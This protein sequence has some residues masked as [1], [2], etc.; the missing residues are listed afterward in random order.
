MPR[1]LDLSGIR[2]F[3]QIRLFPKNQSLY[4]LGHS[5]LFSAGHFSLSWNLL[6]RR[7]KTTHDLNQNPVPA[8]CFGKLSKWGSSGKNEEIKHIIKTQN[9][10]YLQGF[11]AISRHYRAITSRHQ[12]A[13]LQMKRALHMAACFTAYA[14]LVF[15]LAIGWSSLPFSGWCDWP[16]NIEK[17]CCDHSVDQ[18]RP[19][20]KDQIVNKGNY[21]K[22]ARNPYISYKGFL[23]GQLL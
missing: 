14:R 22:K 12:I 15:Y 6:Q 19:E 17:P 10:Q 21:S 20:F 11:P 23:R 1:I 4:V 5:S 3:S 13:P 8:S 16:Q 9:S 18:I 7:Q 2:L